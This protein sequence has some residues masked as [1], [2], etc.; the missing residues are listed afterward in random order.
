MKSKYLL[1]VEGET[2][3]GFSAWFPDL[4]GVFATGDSQRQLEVLAREAADEGLSELSS[5]PVT[6]P[7]SSRQIELMLRGIVTQEK[8]STVSI[9]LEVP[10]ALLVLNQRCRHEMTKQQEAMNFGTRRWN[11]FRG[12]LQRTVGQVS[13]GKR[14]Q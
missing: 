8:L 4:P 5:L 1:V 12:R 11:N 13:E 9:E 7:R 3:K 6:Q 14:V 2:G 10:E